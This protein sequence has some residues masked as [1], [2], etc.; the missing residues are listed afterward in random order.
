MQSSISPKIRDILLGG[1]SG[2]LMLPFRRLISKYPRLDIHIDKDL[3]PVLF[4]HEN[5]LSTL[6]G[7]SDME[8]NRIDVNANSV[9]PTH[10]NL[11]NQPIL[12]NLMHPCEMLHHRHDW[13][14]DC[15]AILLRIYQMEAFS[16]E[17]ER[18]MI[19]CISLWNPQKAEKFL[20]AFAQRWAEWSE[21]RHEAR[22]RLRMHG[23][24]HEGDQRKLVSEL[25]S[26]YSV[27]LKRRRGFDFLRRYYN[28]RILVKV[29]QVLVPPQRPKD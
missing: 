21:V 10:T 14:H 29:L 1:D 4:K 20:R 24:G 16:K 28:R 19:H 12:G 9:E 15:C 26:I 17:H 2:L 22:R 11:P 5:M 7:R 18:H 3:T 23:E 6:K 27:S 13:A 8:F 25:F